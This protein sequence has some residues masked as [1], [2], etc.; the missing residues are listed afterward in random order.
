MIVFSNTTPFIA[1]SCIN[2]LELLPK[3]FE[4]VHVA[5][6]VV[7]EYA[8]G[9]PIFVPPLTA[10]PWV[11]PVA[12]LRN[13]TISMLFELDRGEK[14]T[15]LLARQFNA[16]K[17]LIDERIGRNT[18]EYLGLSVSGTLGVLAKARSMG[19]INSFHDAA[20]LMQGKGIRYNT[21]L[22]TR[23]ARHLGE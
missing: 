9:G 18:A 11:I 7:D 4:K 13:S 15:I 10:L 14:Q 21:S 19:I 3:I 20:M 8:Q 22:I 2:R 17:V 5:Q 16:D 6:A 1:L 23:I 12:D